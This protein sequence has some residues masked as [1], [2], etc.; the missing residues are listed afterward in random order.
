LGCKTTCCLKKLA[1]RA[2]GDCRYGIIAIP[3][4]L[5]P[6]QDDFYQI[7]EL[8][9]CIAKA[10]YGIESVLADPSAYPDAQVCRLRDQIV[11]NLSTPTKL[12]FATKII[13]I[14]KDG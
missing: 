9:V 7:P 12:S 8:Q 11:S 3:C 6:K 13:I 14:F 1:A 4:Y 10:L 2:Y 5:N